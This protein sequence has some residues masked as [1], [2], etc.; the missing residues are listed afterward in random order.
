MTG[1]ATPLKILVRRRKRLLAQLGEGAVAVLPAAHEVPRNRDTHYPFRQDSDFLYLTGFNEPDAVLVLVPGRE[2]GECLLFVR[3]HDPEKERW[4]GR[5]AGLA[6]ALR[7]FGADEAHAIEALDGILPA[8]LENRERVYLPLGRDLSFDARMMSCVNGIRARVRA[9]IRAPREFHDIAPLVHEMRLFKD[10][11][12][13][14]LMREAARVSA[15]AHR[16]VMQQCRPGMFEYQL[17]AELLHAFRHEGAEASFPPIVAA[18]AHAT[19]LHYCENQAVLRKGEL[20][21]VDA[22]AE[23]HGYAGDITRVM[24]VSGKFSKGQ[25]ELT[26]LVISAQMAAIAAVRPGADWDAPHRAA[27]ETLTQ[28]LVEIGLLKGRVGKLIEKEAYR[29]FYMHRTGHWLGL[30]VHDVG[31]YKIDGRWRPLEP[32]MVLT[33]EPGLYVG[34]EEDIPKRY[35]NIGIRIEDDVR[36]TREGHEVLTDSVPKAPDEIEALMAGAEV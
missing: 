3:P 32:G 27:V 29:R 33:V 20:L 35:R 17:E 19:I 14:E 16:R 8:L 34:D 9:G 26:E 23:M 13:I 1:I 15:L 28:G 12:E 36:V 4:D 11:H 5:R 18:G 10:A 22:G 30:D 24:P 7:D 6:G 25:R 2:E 21:L 31:E